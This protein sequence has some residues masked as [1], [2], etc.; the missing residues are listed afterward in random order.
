MFRAVIAEGSI[1]GASEALGYTA[2]AVSQ[3]VSALQRARPDAGRTQRSR[4]SGPPRPALPLATGSVRVFD[5]LARVEAMV[6]DLRN[7][8][9]GG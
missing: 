7:H 1:G 6:S 9:S 8:R 5:E 3:H 4:D 2:S